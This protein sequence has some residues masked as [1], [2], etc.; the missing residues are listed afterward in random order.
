MEN[1]FANVGNV[2]VGE[3]YIHRKELEDRL[4]K[5]TVTDDDNNYGSVNL[6]GLQRMGKSSLVYNT[7]ALEAK[8]EEYYEKNIIIAQLS[9]NTTSSAD[10]FFKDL[11]DAIYE[12][13]DDH[14]D[15]D[16]RLKRYYEEFKSE[17]IVDSGSSNLRRFFK[18]IKKAGKRVVCIIDEF[19]NC[20]NIFEKFPAG[21]AILRQL[22]YEPETHVA[23]VFVSRRLAEELES[24]CE[25]ISPFHNILEY[26][27]VKGFSDEEMKDY[28]ISCEKSGVK[29]ND[30]EKKTLMSIT[31]GQPYWADI[32]LKEYKDAKD[33]GE[34][35]DLGTIFN[36]KIDRI[37]KEYEHMLDLLK[38]QGQTRPRKP[39]GEGE[40]TLDLLEDHGLKSKLYQLVFG[41]MDDCTKADIQTL[42]NYGVIT[43]NK[44]CT[45]ISEK[46]YE[47]MK[48]KEREVKFYPLWHETETGLRKILKSKLKN[49]YKPDW[50]TEVLNNYLLT[51][52]EGIMET[53]KKY[54]LLSDKKSDSCNYRDTTYTRKQYLLS[55]DLSDAQGQKKNLENAK[56][57]DTVKLDAEITILEA[58]YTKGLFLLCE[59]EYK[60]L[61]MDKIFGDL[62]KFI[63]KADHLKYARNTYQ[64]NNDI[65]LTEEY[66]K[67][68]KEYCQ[69]LCDKMREYEKK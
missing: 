61:Q 59:F 19:D 28:Y 46:L 53:L 36:E 39:L 32:L 8:A 10:I 42:Y 29:L 12:V 13:I 50:E 47:Y 55:S 34:N 15:V 33:N 5:R 4:L 63:E 65:L 44:K 18:R 20:A 56:N 31:G 3:A 11:A 68:T 26:I 40:H 52:P 62:D 51:D 17:N 66:K 35:T 45:L 64:H 2:M 6:V 23:F 58:I 37:Y 24:K 57:Y 69:E 14:D 60:K 41:P 30:E 22:A 48:M 21:F 9:A 54:F 25:G 7:L 1:R 38:E 67:K 49:T 27:Y 16:D 43:D